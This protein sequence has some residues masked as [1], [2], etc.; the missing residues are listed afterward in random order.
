MT[1]GVDADIKGTGTE[2]LGQGGT[3]HFLGTVANRGQWVEHT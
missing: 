3:Q 1:V 2:E